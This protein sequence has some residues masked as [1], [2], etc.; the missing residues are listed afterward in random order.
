MKEG[1]S[2]M[3]KRIQSSNLKRKTDSA[4]TQKKRPKD[5]PVRSLDFWESPSL[6]ELAA[7]Q[8]VKPITDIQA[9]LGTWPGEVDD[10]FEE[11]IDHLRRQNMAG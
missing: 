10:G 9:I 3:A 8:N 6:E 11:F 7:R 5:H 4:H 2:T 1:K